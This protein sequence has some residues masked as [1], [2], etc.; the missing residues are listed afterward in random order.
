VPTVDAS[1]GGSAVAL[2]KTLAKASAEIK[3]VDRVIVGHE[4]RSDGGLT[5]RALRWSDFQEY[6][7]FVQDLVTAIQSAKKAGK[8]ADAAASSLGLPAMYG[9]YDLQ[10][11][12][13][14]VEIA[15]REL[16]R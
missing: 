15:Y 4:L 1:L 6:A 13:A 14:F 3:E 8:S 12:P 16:G 10:G 9:T 5:Y 2:A 11:A 7:R